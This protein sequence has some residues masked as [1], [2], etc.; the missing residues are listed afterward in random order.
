MKVKPLESRATTHSYAFGTQHNADGVVSH[1]LW[2]ESGEPLAH[3]GYQILY[4]FQIQIWG[5]LI[6]LF[7]N[8]PSSVGK[9]VQQAH[10]QI[11]TKEGGNAKRMISTK[12]ENLTQPEL[13]L[14][15][16]VAVRGQK[17]GQEFPRPVGSHTW[18]AGTTKGLMSP[19]SRKQ[20]AV[21]GLDRVKHC[22]V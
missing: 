11:I 22:T 17:V 1:R 18:S 14:K 3:V 8:T 15:A 19:W 6:S 20:F 21:M 4:Y 7:R 13:S 12:E 9:T 16:R 5:W 10:E 2:W